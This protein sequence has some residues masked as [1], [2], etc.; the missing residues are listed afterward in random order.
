MSVRVSIV[1]FFCQL[2]LCRS[3][4]TTTHR[5]H[6]S[7]RPENKTTAATLL[8][9]SLLLSP[10]A[11]PHNRTTT[12]QLP[13]LEYF[14]KQ[15][16]KSMAESRS[17]DAV[18]DPVYTTHASLNRSK[19]RALYRATPAAISGSQRSKFF[20]RPIVPFLHAVPPEVMLA[21]AGPPGQKNDPLQPPQAVPTELTRTIG[22]Q[23]QYRETEAQTD[24]YTPDY[25]IRPGEKEPEVLSLAALSYTRGL[26]AGA[27]EVEMIERARA[28][29]EF[30]RSLPPTTDES[31]FQ[32]RRQMMEEQ[33][34]R[35]W[36]ARE[37]EIDRIQ[38][39]RLQMLE[40][41][42]EE[43]EQETEF[44][45][46]QR[47]ETLRQKRLDEKERKVA[48]IQRQR[49]KA[50]RKLSTARKQANPMPED[51]DIIRQYHDYGSNAYAPTRRDGA[52]ATRSMKA[53][54]ASDSDAASLDQLID[55]Q[56]TLPKSTLEPTISVPTATS[57]VDNM[58]V[59]ERRH[60]NA[61][62]GHLKNMDRLLRSGMFGK[63]PPRERLQPSWRK[64]VKK[65]V[66]PVTPGR[67]A[68]SVDANTEEL[69]R[70]LLLLKRLLRGRAVQNFMF[71]GKERRIA[72]IRELR[73]DET[74]EA[75]RAEEHLERTKA[76]RR[77]EQAL[78]STQDTIQG[79]V[80]SATG[81]FLS[82]ELVRRQQESDIA[83]MVAAGERTRRQREAEESGRR[84]AEEAVR[85]REDEV[86]TQMMK[87][88]Q[89][90][91]ES[92]VDEVSSET[93][94]N[95]SAERALR[96]A[97]V[98]HEE[99][100]KVLFGAKEDGDDL[101]GNGRVV[102]RDLVAQFLMPEVDRQDL[103][104]QVEMEEKRFVNAAQQSI[105]EMVGD[106]KKGLTEE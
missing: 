47:V 81:D 9:N 28:K 15:Q 76:Q 30:E 87:V 78:I 88:H 75:Q 48:S 8:S 102:V 80:L 35:E 95:V 96:E 21:P 54:A 44:L 63:S 105:Q 45:A 70:A 46:E 42:L 5:S 26:P 59:N 79:E 86:F 55:M 56:R 27:A 52:A 4:T 74:D 41:A 29:R 97:G 25:T 90:T 103:K 58:R 61:I 24:P 85:N 101:N 84:Q 99:L 60:E 10:G 57:R 69:Q 49:I 36:K 31:S 13:L 7:L 83:E 73:T 3:N 66:R 53:I 14:K 77:L 67:N 62:T 68:P 32:I 94:D 38:A 51:N 16:P 50:L 37:A 43:R 104:R 82:K 2:C 11:L 100:Q 40:K 33:E 34:T 93:I 65:T 18:Y 71:E 12:Q 64:K 1:G 20:R 19:G 98:A 6:Q 106:V 22:V 39:R 23:S 72:L 91:V 92:F 17:Y 89:G